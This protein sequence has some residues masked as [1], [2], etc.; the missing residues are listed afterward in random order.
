MSI[1]EKNEL[2]YY[3]D[4]FKRFKTEVSQIRNSVVRRAVQATAS[5]QYTTNSQHATAIVLRMTPI[6]VA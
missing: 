5:N 6:F 2:Y 1:A 4:E 3:D